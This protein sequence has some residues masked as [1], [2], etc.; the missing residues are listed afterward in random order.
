M[1]M[2][3]WA[4]NELALAGYS[5]SDTEEGPNKWLRE[6][7]LELL[8]VFCEQG[9]IGF[10]APYVV[11]QFSRLASWRP[12]T[13]LTGA[14]DEWG[15]DTAPDQ[16]NRFTEVF[17]DDDGQAFWTRGIVF[18][19]WVEDEETEGRYKSFFT[20]IKSRVYIEFPFTVPDEPEYREFI[21]EAIS[22]K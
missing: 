14:D 10:S 21:E 7:T 11:G 8:K 18:W 9:H 6:N 5:E 3:T 20:N 17:I 22:I 12:L 4:K 2:I 1:D 19:R 16:N 15:T 13:P